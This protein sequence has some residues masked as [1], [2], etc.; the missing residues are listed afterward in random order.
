MQLTYDF[1]FLKKPID[2]P[3][4]TFS[5]ASSNLA[6]LDALTLVPSF[7]YRPIRSVCAI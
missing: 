6:G 3:T 1:D 5:V 7:C 2:V 4:K